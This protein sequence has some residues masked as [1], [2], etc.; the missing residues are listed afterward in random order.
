M[1]FDKKLSLSSF[2]INPFFSPFRSSIL[3]NELN[4]SD[5][6]SEGR[7]YLD[8]CLNSSNHQK[9][10]LLEKPKITVIVPLYNCERTIEAALHSIQYQNISKF[11]MILINDFSKDNN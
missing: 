11:E 6:F 4:K 7:K 3:S 2:V 8:K 1:L 5:I 10:K 9:Y